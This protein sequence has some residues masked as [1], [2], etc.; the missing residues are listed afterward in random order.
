[1][2]F[3]LTQRIRDQ[4]AIARQHV[5]S[6]P[7]ACKTCQM[8]PRS[9]PI[10]VVLLVVA[11]CAT[12]DPGPGSSG[13][14][15]SWT[16]SPDSTAAEVVGVDA[17]VE[18]LASG[19]A[20]APGEF[21]PAAAPVDIRVEFGS[22]AGPVTVELAGEAPP[23]GATPVVLHR[24]EAGVWESSRAD[25]VDGVYRVEAMS[26]SWYWPG[27][28]EDGVEWVGGAI[29]SGWDWLTG[30]TDPPE[31]CSTEPPY[32]WVAGTGAPPDGAYHVCYSENRPA[33]G[34]E[35]VEV[36][37]KSNRALAMWVIVPRQGADYVWVEGSTWDTVGPVM[38]QVSGASSDAVLLGPGR[39]LTV[40]YQR[41]VELGSELEFFAYQDAVSQ[42]A[43][44]LQRHAGEVVGE[45][46]ALLATMNC[47]N[48]GVP[49][50]SGFGWDQ[51]A[52]CFS[53]AIRFS[54]AHAESLVVDAIESGRLALSTGDRERLTQELITS[55][56]L[57]NAA[58]Q[59]STVS[60]VFDAGRLAAD[61]VVMVR[62]LGAGWAD[63]A[64]RLSIKL[65]P[66][67]VVDEGDLPA[68]EPGDSDESSTEANA[69][70]VVE[71]AGCEGPR[72]HPGD[73]DR[74]PGRR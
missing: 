10:H 6:D 34:S 31:N 23:D 20:D 24:N 59:L 50:A 47:W 13:A 4:L 69:A 40:G 70:E 27:W 54:G 72:R 38:T 26:F 14:G 21:V 71:A 19:A 16:G 57:R 7:G 63:Q 49:V 25:F 44:L 52:S 37:I 30:R 60:S 39:T 8:A 11:G 64:G 28:V 68:E 15:T 48:A 18:R 46:G 17:T 29:D 22:V 43:S 56:R 65:V 73:D 67:A 12:S 58:T 45:V 2:S 35:R 53:S 3:E 5:R 62:D 36:R 41:P 55:G 33:N 66:T 9:W 61:G 32:E 74:R 51:A 42:F 1:M